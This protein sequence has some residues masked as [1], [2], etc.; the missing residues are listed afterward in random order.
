MKIQYA[1]T[2]GQSGPKFAFA[3]KE[4]RSLATSYLQ[5]RHIDAGSS[6]LQ[7]MKKS[8]DYGKNLYKTRGGELI[9]TYMCDPETADVEFLLSKAK[10]KAITGREQKRDA[11][12][13][14][15]QMRQSFP[16]GEVDAETALKLAYDFALRWT[17]GKHAFIV[18]SHIDR[19]HSHTHVY[20]NSTSLDCTRKFRDFWGSA[21]AVQ[22]LSDRICLEN[23]LSIVTDRKPKSKGKYK[24]YGEWLGD[25]RQPSF[26]ER[27]KAQIDACLAEKP[28]S[29]EAFLEVMTAAGYEV[30]H[31][32]G[33]ALSFR[34]EGQERPTRLRSSTLGKGYG[35]ENIQAIIKGHAPLPGSRIKRPQQIPP[36]VNLIVDIQAKM[37]TGKGPAY[38][39]WAKVHNLKAMAVA[40]QFLRENDLL[41]YTQL[42]QRA[43]EI[44]DHFHVLSD[45]IK[46]LETAMNTN[47]ELRAAMIDYAKTRPIFEGYK[48]AKYS[49]KYLAE[50]EADIQRYRAAQATFK[51]VLAGVKLPKMDTLKR[52]TQRLRTE[53]STAYREYRAAQESMRNVLTAKANI[54][55]LLSLTDSRKNKDK[56][57]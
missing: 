46:S 41:E 18:M 26:K 34:I 10:Y 54:D 30:I 16:P 39:Q 57:R 48:A 6:I 44:A 33:G 32:R 42:E 55:H 19:P 35:P 14:L 2:S 11:D 53:K 13:L 22:R 3:G 28:E 15:Y 25:N 38:E 23:G 56:E 7:S 5:K 20:Y 8:I 9:T 43:A 47:G 29:F 49:N 37:R 51:R 1:A 27:L 40:L 45:K 4:G 21:R 31:G 24:H 17:K 12:V 50:H 52:E 36:K